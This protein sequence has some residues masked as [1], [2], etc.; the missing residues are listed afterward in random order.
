MALARRVKKIVASLKS[1]GA[2]GLDGI[3]VNVLKLGIVVLAGTI[4]KLI[5]TSLSTCIVPRAFKTARVTPVFKGKGKNPEDPGSYRPI[6]IL[7]VLSKVLEVAVKEDLER[8]LPKVNGLPNSQFGFRKGRSTAAA[9][10]AAHA[11]W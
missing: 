8:H 5:N 1:T 7:P 4:A 2:M 11:A 9:I 10:A 3:P 6:A